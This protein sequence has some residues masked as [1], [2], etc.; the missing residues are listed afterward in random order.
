[1]KIRVL[2]PGV[3]VDAAPGQP[4]QDALFPLGVEF[5]CGGRGRCKGCRVQVIEGTL[6]PHPMDL[7]LFTPGEIA[8]G[9]RLACRA[10][11]ESALVLQVRQ[12]DTLILSD[13]TPLAFEP[14]EGLGVAIDLG[15]T[16]VVAQLLDL[17]T[18]QVRAVRTG[19]NAQAK[20]GADVMS[21]LEHALG[22]GGEELKESV[23]RQL[24][25]MTAAL[26]KSAGAPWEAVRKVVVV[27]NTVMQH[28]MW[29]FPLKQLALAPHV[30]HTVAPLAAP[31]SALG[32]DLPAN[33]A[34]HFLPNLGGFVGSD[35]LAG[36]LATR[37]LESERLVAAADLGTNG[38]I[39]AG[40][41]EGIIVSSTAAGPAFEGG[42]IELG[43]RAGKGAIARVGVSDHRMDARVIGGGDP[44]GVC[45][46]GLVDAVAAALDLELLAPSGRLA[47]GDRL[48]VAPP[49]YITQRDIRELQLAK[50]A[51]AAGLRMLLE[52]LGKSLEDVTRFYL[53]GAFGNTLGVESA[54]KIGL[55]KF[56]SERTVPVGNAALRGAKIALLS[57]NGGVPPDLQ[58][59]VRF[60]NLGSRPR[61]QE[62]FADE[63]WLGA[64]A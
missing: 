50:A 28:L 59:H 11:V 15:T 18:G 6:P 21:R 35:I 53:A 10:R 62:L 44:R 43:M 57:P 39:V 20:W 49:V 30:P 1:M 37:M 55:F 47:D 45:G 17:A 63:M 13:N 46:S 40:S 36:I 4:L 52:E 42:R 19:L 16:T 5:P 54:E 34:V 38:E 9:W 25:G 33:V 51:I 27:G 2:P 61:F 56:G 8:E 32:W 60:L 48:M 26:V 23:N 58:R 14:R 31:S 41:R 7:A 12:W 22:G 64:E 29:G 24:A 3:E